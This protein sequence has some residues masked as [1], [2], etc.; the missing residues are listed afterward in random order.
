[1]PDR[2]GWIECQIKMSSIKNMYALLISLLGVKALLLAVGGI[3][4][5]CIYMYSIFAL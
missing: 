2:D 3:S 5:A 1:M 4:G